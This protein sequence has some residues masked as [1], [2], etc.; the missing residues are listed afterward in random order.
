MFTDC[1]QQC[2]AECPTEVPGPPWQEVLTTPQAQPTF[3][4]RPGGIVQDMI[5][6]DLSRHSQTLSTIQEL[7]SG[8]YISGGGDTERGHVSG[9]HIDPPKGPGDLY[10]TQDMTAALTACQGS[11]LS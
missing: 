5:F 1:C 2:R 10:G 3:K 6:S 8:E 7:A 4:F 9:G 11:F